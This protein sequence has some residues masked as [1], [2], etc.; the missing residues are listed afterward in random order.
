MTRTRHATFLVFRYQPR[1]FKCDTPEISLYIKRILVTHLA[2]V[3]LAR[4]YSFQGPV[5][6]DPEEMNTTAIINRG[7][8][9]QQAILSQL[10]FYRPVL[11]LFRYVIAVFVLPLGAASARFC[12]RSVLEPRTFAE[13]ERF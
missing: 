4:G 9:R 2:S 6:S 3:R 13:N 8:W 5:F 12:A 1:T 10:I 7:H 11:D